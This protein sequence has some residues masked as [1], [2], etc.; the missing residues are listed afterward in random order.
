MAGSSRYG[1]TSSS[2]WGSPISTGLVVPYNTISH[3]RSQYRI[4][5]YQAGAT[6]VITNKTPNAPARG[7]GRVTAAFVIERVLDRVTR[8]LD[9]DP[10]ASRLVLSYPRQLGRWSGRIGS[11]H[12]T[13]SLNAHLINRRTV[14]TPIIRCHRSAELLGGLSVKAVVLRE[15]YQLIVAAQVLDHHPVVPPG[16]LD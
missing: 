13:P 8:G 4:D 1:T 16:T 10:A 11:A 15:T 12:P 6:C 5:N 2:T 3:L 14:S 9:I 7:A